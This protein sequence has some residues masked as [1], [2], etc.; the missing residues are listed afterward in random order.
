MKKLAYVPYIKSII[1]IFSLFY[2]T[3]GYSQT[4]QKE[5]LLIWGQH[6]LYARTGETTQGEFEIA[7]VAPTGNRMDNF[8]VTSTSKNLHIYANCSTTLPFS[9]HC[10]VDYSYHPT[11]DSSATHTAVTSKSVKVTISYTEKPPFAQDAVRKN[12]TTFLVLTHQDSE[13]I[14]SMPASSSDFNSIPSP[15][16]ND[17]FFDKQSQLFYVATDNGISIFDTG[18]MTMGR[19]WH[20]LTTT[21]SNM[22][23]NIENPMLEVPILISAYKNKIGVML[24]NRVTGK[25]ML[26]YSNKNGGNWVTLKSFSNAK[27]LIVTDT[28]IYVA[29]HDTVFIS[30]NGGATWL[31]NIFYGQTVNDMAIGSVYDNPNDILFVA[32][33]DGLYSSEKGFNPGSAIISDKNCLYQQSSNSNGCNI[34]AVIYHGNVLLAAAGE[35]TSRIYVGFQGGYS[36]SGTQM[37]SQNGAFTQLSAFKN[38]L[39]ASD[40]NALFVSKDLGKTYYKALDLTG[41]GSAHTIAQVPGWAGDTIVS[42]ANG[43]KISDDY[44]IQWSSPWVSTIPGAPITA[45]STYGQNDLFMVLSGNLVHAYRDFFNTWKTKTIAKGGQYIQP[46]RRGDKYY[47]ATNNSTFCSSTE[48]GKSFSCYEMKQHPEFVIK[49]FAISFY[50]PSGQDGSVLVAGCDTADCFEHSIYLSHDNGQTWEKRNPSGPNTPDLSQCQLNVHADQKEV[51]VVA[52]NCRAP[53][54]NGMYQ[55]KS[56]GDPNTWTKIFSGD[57]IKKAFFWGTYAVATQKTDDSPTELQC[58]QKNTNTWQSINLPHGKYS[59]TRVLEV[60]FPTIYISVPEIKDGIRYDQIEVS[61]DTGVDW[62]TLGRIFNINKLKPDF[63]PIAAFE[64][65]ETGGA[66]IATTSGLYFVGTKAYPPG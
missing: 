22:H 2:A 16:I 32:T 58:Y 38:T 30:P 11:K 48:S 8:K 51:D 59:A 7:N 35:S 1:I 66:Y 36:W 26:I 10:D 4:A 46:T 34:S 17:M 37:V 52:Q 31:K 49:H 21:G 42:S 53:A 62:S 24:K 57:P 56:N 18:Y 45:L 63:D 25:E 19:R 20:T 23:S 14:A 15:N 12:T 65:T 28:S 55:S 27:E 33:T 13:H 9:D 47:Y 5:D 64:T 41:N 3:L 44:G 29:T 6:H 61:N 60:D 40:K 54:L 39:I 50:S 43:I